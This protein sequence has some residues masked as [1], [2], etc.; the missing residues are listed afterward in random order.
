MPG[1][2]R[3]GKG[4]EIFKR[5]MCR[6]KLVL[7]VSTTTM[8]QCQELT[9]KVREFRYL[10]VRERQINKLNRLL[11]KRKEIQLGQSTPYP[12]LGRSAGP[13]S[14]NLQPG[15]S[16]GTGSTQSPQAGWRPSPSNGTLATTAS[17]NC[18]N[19][20]GDVAG[21]SEDQGGEPRVTVAPSKS[22]TSTPYNASRVTGG[23]GLRS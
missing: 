4:A 6:T 1:I 15:K 8:Q 12:Q 3:Q 17:V 13:D 9:D 23:Q 14:S 10:K 21:N 18:H 5:D 7:I 19:S 2:D 11:Q 20:L 22:A 16:E